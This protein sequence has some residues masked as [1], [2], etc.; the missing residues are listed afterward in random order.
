MV[1][2]AARDRPVRRQE[3]VGDNHPEPSGKVEPA[4][5][6]IEGRRPSAQ[7]ITPVTF[8]PT[9]KSFPGW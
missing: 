6:D 2:G 5:A 8:F 1:V 3:A 9:H 7:S 4:V